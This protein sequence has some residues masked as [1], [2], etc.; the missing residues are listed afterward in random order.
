MV[1]LASLLPMDPV[2]HR[3]ELA[4]VVPPAILLAFS[5]SIVVLSLI[6]GFG[7]NLTLVLVEDCMDNLLAGGVAC[8][9]VEQLLCCLWFA[10]SKLMN[11]CFIGHARDECFDH[12][13]IHNIGKL[14]ALLGKAVD[15][16]T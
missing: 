11:E 10:V 16:L 14:N 12:I 1:E 9:E 15:V 6:C 7:L 3:D 8:C 13:R 5:P 4:V 2:N